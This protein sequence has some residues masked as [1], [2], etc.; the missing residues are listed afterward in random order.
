MDSDIIVCTGSVGKT[1]MRRSLAQSIGEDKAFTPKTNYCNEFG[2]LLS[3]LGIENFSIF[4][5]KSWKKL[6][7]KKP[8]S[9]QFI[10][11]ELGADFRMDI[12]WFLKRWKP[13]FVIFTQGTEVAWTKDLARVIESRVRLCSDVDPKNILVSSGDGVHLK[14]LKDKKVQ[15]TLVSHSD[16][17]YSYAE[18]VF[19]VFF[20]RNRFDCIQFKPFYK[21]RFS[22]KKKND[23][24]LI[25]DMY[26]VT[27]VCLSNFLE[28]M[29]K[30][31]KGEKI[32]ILNEI[33][34]SIPEYGLV[35]DEF[36]H[37]LERVDKIYFYGDEKVFR[38]L[39]S[40][41]NNIMLVSKGA[42][43]E[44]VESIKKYLKREAV[45]VGIK[46]SSFY[47]LTPLEE[48]DI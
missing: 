24:I 6:L 42:L 45:T 44:L 39:S 1:I 17:V 21:N 28:N 13:S 19:S 31:S 29:L 4:S 2:V 46:T 22:Y 43:G 35:Y 36:I 48:I 11:I 3:V 27:P 18:E 16:D 5:F 23:I 12:D 47:K 40:R 8:L 32:L 10:L 30:E 9:Y 34:P 7:F 41:L 14:I 38:Y 25:K 26:K 15:F 33:R 20:E 37:S